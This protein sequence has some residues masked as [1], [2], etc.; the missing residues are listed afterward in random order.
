MTGKI[1]MDSGAF[2]AFTLGEQQDL[3]TYCAWLR[4]HTKYINH[5]AV[6]DVIGS[7]EGT[8]ENQV[9]MEETGD[10]ITP[11]PCFHYGEDP[12]HLRRYI[13]Q[14]YPYLALGG[15]VPISTKDLYPWLDDLWENY[16]TNENGEPIIRVHG[17]GLTTFELMDRYPWFS[18]DSSSWLKSAHFGLILF[19]H[20]DKMYRVNVSEKSGKTGVAGQHYLTETR[21]NK[22]AL[23]AM[24]E[25][26]GHNMAQLMKHYQLR[27][28][29][30][31]STYITY[32]K[33]WK[34]TP[35]VNRER[36]LFMLQMGSGKAYAYKDAAE[37][38]PW[39]GLEIY[40]AGEV[41]LEVERRLYEINANRMFSY[42]YVGKRATK[43]WTAVKGVIDGQ[44]F[45]PTTNCEDKDEAEPE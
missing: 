44:P 17:F 5:Y 19:Y 14:G 30:N 31:C 40:F 11:V 16:L 8:Y 21:A 6:L 12:K 34:A 35:F 38:W 3:P 18:V 37:G 39:N 4:R 15:M 1:W 42:H 33:R 20:G 10:D 26:Q 23:D 27:D 22:R 25:A 7:A 45:P 43:Q 41:T 2:S 36:G 9:K 28:A 29:F 24:V 32:G 13:D